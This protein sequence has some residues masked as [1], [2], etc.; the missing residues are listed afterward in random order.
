MSAGAG[1]P[2]NFHISTCAEPAAGAKQIRI[3]TTAKRTDRFEKSVYCIVYHEKLYAGQRY[4][5]IPNYRKL[6]LFALSLERLLFDNCD[7]FQSDERTGLQIGYSFSNAG[8]AFDKENA[9]KWYSVE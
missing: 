8:V 5:F 9:K 7:I 2:F 3:S 1:G 6:T 4:N